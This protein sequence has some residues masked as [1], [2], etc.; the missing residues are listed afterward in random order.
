MNW[1][2]LVEHFPV[3]VKR[4]DDLGGHG[5]AGLSA[6]DFRQMKMAEK[7]RLDY[8]DYG[9][10]KLPFNAISAL[11]QTTTLVSMWPHRYLVLAAT[12]RETESILRQFDLAPFEI[13][14]VHDKDQLVGLGSNATVVLPWGFERNPVIVEYGIPE[15]LSLV[16]AGQPIENRIVV[17]VD[18]QP[19]QETL[20]WM[21]PQC[22]L[23][24]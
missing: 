21:G 14:W 16:L 17:L 2:R 6:E 13:E 8:T 1:N 20:K 10:S 12:L 15:T 3:P 19:R 9:M 23:A 18:R 24:R 5:G 11:A 7:T 22:V 4:S